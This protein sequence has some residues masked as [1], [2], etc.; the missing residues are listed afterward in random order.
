MTGAVD[1]VEQILSHV[2]PPSAIKYW[3]DSPVP[4]LGSRTPRELV[5]AGD[6]AVVLDLARSC[7][8]VLAAK[9]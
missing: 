8:N 4:H 5:A 3:L 2:L 1:Q 7:V 9:R 6:S